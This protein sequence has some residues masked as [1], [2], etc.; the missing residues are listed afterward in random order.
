MQGRPLR[1]AASGLAP[2]SRF[3]PD[4]PGPEQREARAGR[5]HIEIVSHCWHYAHLLVYQLRSLVL[6]PAR[7]MGGTMTVY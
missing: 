1:L 5:L 4:L 3:L 2:A 7:Q 6:F